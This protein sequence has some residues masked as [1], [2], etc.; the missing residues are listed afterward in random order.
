MMRKQWV[1]IGVAATAL[2]LAVFAL[3]PREPDGLDFIRKYGPERE[4]F[5]TILLLGRHSGTGPTTTWNKYFEFDE[6]P[7][8]LLQYL[9]ER[10]QNPVVAD[11]HFFR[12]PNGKEAM[13]MPDF[14]GNDR[15]TVFNVQEPSWI[16]R[17]WE[18]LMDRIFPSVR[19]SSR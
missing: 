10:S 12:L 13:W 7:P 14:A 11:S 18:A 17:Y 8:P 19:Y 5:E 1:W 16:A 15:I 3:L 9:R 6:I 2:I 4:S